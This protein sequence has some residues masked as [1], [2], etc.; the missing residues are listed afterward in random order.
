[1][2]W[3]CLLLVVSVSTTLL[4][5]HPNKECQD[6]HP[7][8]DVIGPLGNR[9]PPSYRRRFN[10]PRYVGGKIAY[11]I[12]PSS[13]EAMAWHE[14]AH[15]GAYSKHRPRIEKHYFY[16]KPWEAL[17][18][19]PRRFALDG[20]MSSYDAVGSE[21]AELEEAAVEQLAPQEPLAKE[22]GLIEE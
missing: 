1:M 12:A 7:R 17:Q 14:A 16:P 19:G 5:H 10:R 6:V 4:A 13:Q 15:L 18:I 11:Y 20:G 2:R 8:I 22:T 21:Y 3:S 9:L